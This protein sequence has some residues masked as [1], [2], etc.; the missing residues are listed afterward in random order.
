MRALVKV[1]VALPVL[2][3]AALGAGYVWLEQAARTPAN[4]TAAEQAPIELKVPKGATLTQVGKLLEEHRLIQSALVFRAFVRIHGGA[5]PK[6]GRHRVHAGMAIPELLAVLADT[7]LS[8]DVPLTMVE[9]WR[10]R[11]ADEWLAAQKLIEVGAYT[12]AASEPSRFQLRF[13]FGGGTLEGY[14][15]PETYMIPPGKLEVDRLIQRQ[16]DAFAERFYAPHK[17][18]IDRSG[19]SLSD[20]VIM[21]SMLEREEPDPGRRP[22]VAGVL[23]KRLD[24]RTPLGVDA[25][26]RYLLADWN[27]RRTFLTALRDP[28]EPYNTRLRAGL[29]PGPIGAP[30]V[31]SLVAAL[32]PVKS[33]Y[34][35]YLHDGE[36]RI[37]FARTAEEHE[38]NRR[39]YNVY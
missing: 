24:A 21:A 17:E 5:A 12:R 23:Y 8:D 22:E 3:V 37:H 6:A 30:G 26:S 20:L 7:P 18:E 10:L 2:G 35:Y 39:R 25:T 28:A 31:E 32:R 11:D 34:W 19:R 16:L 4:P 9:G 1:A 36:R 29:P 33:P 14:L 13:P 27:D 38:E 15:Y